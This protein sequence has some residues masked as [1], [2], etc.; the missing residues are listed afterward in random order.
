MLYVGDT[1]TRSTG[2]VSHEVNAVPTRW[3][4]TVV[5]IVARPVLNSSGA[6][7]IGRIIR[8]YWRYPVGLIEDYQPHQLVRVV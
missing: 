2:P 5:D 1:V 4:G 7:D 3:D 6:N 8:V